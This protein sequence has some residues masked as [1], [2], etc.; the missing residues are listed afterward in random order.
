VKILGD[1]SYLAN[2]KSS[3]GKSCEAKW[4]PSSGDVYVKAPGGA[5]KRANGNHRAHSAGEAAGMA[6]SY[7][8]VN[9]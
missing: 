4:D 1:Y 7:A 9:M 8:Q 6:I 3:A 5:W 2:V